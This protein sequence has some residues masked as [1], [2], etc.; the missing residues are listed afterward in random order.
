MHYSVAS[1][2]KILI[3]C[4][5]YNN[6]SSWFSSVPHGECCDKGSVW[7]KMLEFYLAWPKDHWLDPV[8]SP[9]F[10]FKYSTQPKSNFLLFHPE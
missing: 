1:H 3:S 4:S 8:L 2:L 5:N 6:N 10:T 9:K 7:A